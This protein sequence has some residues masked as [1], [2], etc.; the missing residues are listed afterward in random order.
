MSIKMK[1]CL[2]AGSQK[3][4]RKKHRTSR[5]QPKS[6]LSTPAGDCSVKHCPQPINFCSNVNQPAEDRYSLQRLN[7]RF[8]QNA[9]RF[10]CGRRFVFLSSPA[11]ASTA[12]D[13]LSRPAQIFTTPSEVSKPDA[14]V[15]SAVAS[16]LASLLSDCSEPVS[17]SQTYSKTTS[18]AG[19]NRTPCEHRDLMLS[20]RSGT[21]V[22]NRE[23]HRA[24]EFFMTAALAFF[25][26]TNTK[27]YA[28]VNKN[29]RRGMK[30]MGAN[31]RKIQ[32]SLVVT[33]QEETISTRE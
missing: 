5:N 3:I 13:L 28:Q 16:A 33:G 23:L 27:P 11:E 1:M 17:Q 31:V 4:R 12:F 7:R 20:T 15:V 24:S 2:L 30:R 18:G 25:S 14:V 9:F 22:E 29:R 26:Q 32:L 8:H 10:S 19:E 6:L 21:E